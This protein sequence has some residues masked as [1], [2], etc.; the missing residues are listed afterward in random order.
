MKFVQTENI[1]AEFKNWFKDISEKLKLTKGPFYIN[2][3]N[4]SLF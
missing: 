4:V 3:K 2:G 1:E